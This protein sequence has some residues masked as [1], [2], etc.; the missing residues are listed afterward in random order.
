M[1]IYTSENLYR[2]LPAAAVLCVLG[3]E[4]FVVTVLR[5]LRHPTLLAPQHKRQQTKKHD[6]IKEEN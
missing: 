1:Y 4:S 2:R 3:G 6:R 5:H